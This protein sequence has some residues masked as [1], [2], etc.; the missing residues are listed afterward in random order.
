MDKGEKIIEQLSAGTNLA[1]VP[2]PGQPIVEIAGTHRIL[3]ENH[4]GVCAYSS[5]KIVVKVRYGTVIVCGGG[6]KLI[7]MSKVQLIIQGQIDSVL[8]QR[9]G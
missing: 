9:R 8:L 6:L 2:I 7:K 5:E 4:F 3:I 1:E